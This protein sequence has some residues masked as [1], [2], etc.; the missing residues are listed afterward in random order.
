MPGPMQQK[1]DDELRAERLVF[2]REEMSE[3]NATLRAFLQRAKR[4]QADGADPR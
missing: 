4:H 1:T 3:I 2:Y